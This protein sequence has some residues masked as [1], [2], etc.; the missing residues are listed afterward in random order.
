MRLDKYIASTTD[1]SR[2]EVKKLIKRGDIQV[3]DQQA[4]DPAQAL[5]IAQDIVCL[6]EEPLQAPKPRYFMLH[7]PAGTI[8]AKQDSDHPTVIDLLE[9]SNSHQLQI[10]GRLYKDTTGLVLITDDGKWNHR[11]N[12]PRSHCIK[13]YRVCIEEEINNDAI[14]QLETGLPLHHE[15]R[16]TLPAKVT[17][18]DKYTIH[19]SIQ[20]GKYHQITRMLAAVGNR[21]TALHRFQIGAVT[22]DTALDPCAYRPLTQKEVEG[23]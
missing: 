1:Y 6:F 5:N 22:L 7:K 12:S 11:I 13:T 4:S 17:V 10:V 2:Y 16:P 14:K 15:K 3:N 8:C 23:F 21:V 19:L 18:I 9:E 20:E